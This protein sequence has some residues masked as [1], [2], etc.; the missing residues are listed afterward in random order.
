MNTILWI[1]VAFYAGVFTG[2]FWQGSHRCKDE[3]LMH[4]GYS[5][6]DK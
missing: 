3:N 6:A 1:V 2:A 5:D 4:E